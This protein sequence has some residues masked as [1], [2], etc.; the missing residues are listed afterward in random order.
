MNL[1]DLTLLERLTVYAA[2]SIYYT[3]IF[4]LFAVVLFLLTDAMINYLS[5]GEYDISTI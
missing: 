2:M 4:T 3:L 5:L 1:S